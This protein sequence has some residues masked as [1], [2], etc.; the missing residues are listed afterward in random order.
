MAKAIATIYGSDSFGRTFRAAK[1]ADGQWFRSFFEYNARY[2]TK[3]F[4]K[5]A[6]CEAYEPDENGKIWHGFVQVG[7][8]Y[9]TNSY[10]LP[11]V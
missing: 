2:N 1:R 10:R 5:W 8:S 7:I 9:E 3:G 11:N 6:K 4:T